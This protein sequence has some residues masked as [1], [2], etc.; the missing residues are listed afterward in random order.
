MLLSPFIPGVSNR[1]VLLPDHTRSRER[2]LRWAGG[3]ASSRRWGIPASA[4]DR[5][6][7][8]WSEEN[9]RV[10]S[11]HAR[12]GWGSE[13][14]EAAGEVPYWRSE[15]D[16]VCV[17]T[18]SFQKRHRDNHGSN[19]HH[20]TC[21]VP[22]RWFIQSEYLFRAMSIHDLDNTLFTRTIY[23][24]QR[25]HISHSEHGAKFCTNTENVF[26][27]TRS[28]FTLVRLSTAFIS[29]CA[30]LQLITSGFNT[31]AFVFKILVTW[32]FFF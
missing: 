29:T 26:S 25:V 14:C 5:R 20:C 28:N 6:R 12:R 22:H 19:I 4:I 31:D 8:E 27:I 9:G 30:L 17:D 21:V 13:G 11:G 18:I 24:S 23:Y 2:G 32:F 7:A 3:T 16:K 10:G 15:R 1:H